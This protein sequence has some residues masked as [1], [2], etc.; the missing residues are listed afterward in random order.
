MFWI[1]KATNEESVIDEIWKF[2]D[3]EKADAHAKS[4][5]DDPDKWIQESVRVEEYDDDWEPGPGD[6]DFRT[7]D[8]PNE[9]LATRN[10]KRV[11]PSKDVVWNAINDSAKTRFDYKSFVD[12]VTDIISENFLFMT[13]AGHAAGESAEIIA[14]RISQQLLLLGC[15]SS[16]A[17]LKQFIADRKTDCF[18][19][20]KATETAMEL[21]QMGLKTPGILAQVRSLLDKP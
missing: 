10:T 9:R 14:A 13:I 18:R 11:Y 20:I 17:E 8:H 12:S 2:Y 19:E 6:I 4:L 15:S 16:E 5:R 7:I 21:F 3:E 1:V